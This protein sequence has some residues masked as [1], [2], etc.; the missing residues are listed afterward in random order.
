MNLLQEW[1]LKEE[2]IL[3]FE[4]RLTDA[5][6]QAKNIKK[7]LPKNHPLDED[8]LE[9]LS[10]AIITLIKAVSK[11]DPSERRSNKYLPW[12][13][14]MIK[15]YIRQQSTGAY[16]L[17]NFDEDNEYF[18]NKMIRGAE[19]YNIFGYPEDKGIFDPSN[20][21]QKKAV[22]TQVVEENVGNIVEK[23]ENN[24][25]TETPRILSLYHKLAE[26]NLID[27]NINNFKKLD[28]LRDAVNNAER[29]LREREKL[30]AI[31]NQAKEQT[32]DI[33]S[34]EYV[35][36]RRPLSKEG[37]CYF[38]AGTRWCISATESQ[39]YFDQY[40]GEGAGFYFVFFK[41]LPPDDDLKK[42]ALVYRPGD[43]EPS[44]VFDRPDDEISTEGLMTAVEKNILALGAKIAF[45]GQLK[46]LKGD[47]RTSFFTNLISN[48]EREYDGIDDIYGRP[49]SEME[50][51]PHLAKISQFIDIDAADADDFLIDFKEKAREMY[52]EIVGESAAHWEDNPAG[53]TEEDFEAVLEQAELTEVYVS[54]DSYDEARM[55]WSGGWSWDMSDID[56]DKEDTDEIEDAVRKGLDDNY[57]YPD[58]I[59]IDTYGGRFEAMIRIDPAYDEQEG[60]DG[61]KSFV[62]RMSEMDASIEDI[63]KSIMEYFKELGLVDNP[64]KNLA[65]QF[66]ELELM[67]FEV[68]IEEDIVSISTPVDIKV[69]VPADVLRTAGM[70]NSWQTQFTA[71]RELMD[72]H[73]DIGQR[74]EVYEKQL[75]DK[76]GKALQQA[77]E[78]AG[79][80][81]PLP[82]PV[83]QKKKIKKIEPV[84]LN[85]IYRAIG[86]R[87]GNEPLYG[88]QTS[89]WW[90]EI[91]VNAQ[92]SLGDV[93][94]MMAFLK[95]IDTPK[96]IEKIK[97]R[98]QQIIEDDIV[99]N[100]VPALKKEKEEEL[101]EHIYRTWRKCLN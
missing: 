57:V 73:S 27:K 46:K 28:E 96:V 55:Y 52:Y 48:I 37:S 45:K 24:F 87:P 65:D 47:S 97:T 100:V 64:L 14:G 98:I 25:V 10:E 67:N 68:E 11:Q 29:E 17:L 31:E 66:E 89:P 8:Q 83:G 101:A 16:G 51:V 35:E 7:V 23:I 99:K 5:I 71:S 85:L 39:N 19:T 26:R 4:S 32:E 91:Q 2:A 3:L 88:P 59:E 53:P 80:Q 86:L 9:K 72:Y 38:G 93:N 6:A 49:D 56:F 41:H 30:K 90:L 75:N 21:N 54:Y 22:L 62:S 77:Y 44:E 34:N 13:M 12:T 78:Q 60:L 69:P 40:T 1:L 36:I 63:K 33:F 43:D 92:T 76:L 61:F 42:L 81:L 95:A 15:N 74:R 79:K 50:T 18:K 70:Q 94:K 82:E 84:N 58:E 20:S